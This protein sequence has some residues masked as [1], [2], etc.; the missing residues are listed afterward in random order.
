[1]LYIFRQNV[2]IFNIFVHVKNVAP[3]NKER[4]RE[5]EI[6]FSSDVANIVAIIHWYKTQKYTNLYP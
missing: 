1:M 2:Y 4:G 5:R 3:L 6:Y